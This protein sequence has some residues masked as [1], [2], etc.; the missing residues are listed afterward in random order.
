MQAPLLFHC[1]LAKYLDGHYWMWML[2]VLFLNC[3]STWKVEVTLFSFS[4]MRGRLELFVF[5]FH[6]ESYSCPVMLLFETQLSSDSPFWNT[7]VQWCSF[8]KHSCPMMLLFESQL[9]SDAPFWNTAVQWRSFLKHSCPVML[10]FE[11][12]LYSDVPLWNTA[13]QWLSLIH[14]W[15]CRRAAA[16]RSR[17]SPYH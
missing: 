2:P 13:V 15:R 5:I 4:C 14:I 11:I 6:L 7:A 9:S 3:G 10:L 1:P 12:Q 16:C 17:W 8:S